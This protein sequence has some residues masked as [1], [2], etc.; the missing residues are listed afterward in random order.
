MQHQQRAKLTIDDV[1]FGVLTSSRFLETRLRSQK[2]TW[3]RQAR[4]VVFYSEADLAWLPAV[5]LKPPPGEQLIGGGAWK[6]F[7][8]LIDLQRRFPQQKW[9]FFNVRLCT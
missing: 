2:N 6:N 8:A 1:A 5:G 9:I 7:P 3:L 4:H